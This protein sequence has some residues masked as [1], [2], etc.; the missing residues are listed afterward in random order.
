MV[1]SVLH[2]GAATASMDPWGLFSQGV[3][4][5]QGQRLRCHQELGQ[6][7]QAETHGLAA[8]NKRNACSSRVPVPEQTTF[9]ISRF[10]QVTRSQ[11]I[12]VE[13]QVNDLRIRI[14]FLHFW[15]SL[16]HHI[17]YLLPVFSAA[18]KIG[19]EEAGGKAQ[20]GN[21][22]SGLWL[23]QYHNKARSLGVD[24]FIWLNLQKRAAQ[25]ASS[26]MAVWIA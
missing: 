3:V 7:G 9:Q 17:S 8:L 11:V 22:L 20:N 5:T 2:A 12:R 25:D 14:Q 1:V 13:L 19:P 4:D 26:S 24:S 10:P 6:N 16:S 21:C 15:N 18:T 23:Q